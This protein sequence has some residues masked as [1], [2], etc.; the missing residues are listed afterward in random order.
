MGFA[1]FLVTHL[2]HVNIFHFLDIIFQLFYT[3]FNCLAKDHRRGF[4]KCEYGPYCYL[5]PIKNGEYILEK[6]SFYIS[7]IIFFG[8]YTY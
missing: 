4:P 6:V 7:K 5:I 8:E 2:F 3:S 1:S